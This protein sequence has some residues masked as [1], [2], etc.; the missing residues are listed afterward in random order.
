MR[1][2]SIAVTAV[3]ASALAAVIAPT[4]HAYDADTYSYA[5]GHMIQPSDIPSALQMKSAMGFTA[6]QNTD[7]VWLCSDGDTSIGYPGGTDVFY[8][9]Y[10]GKSADQTTTLAESVMQYDSATD[11]IKAF[12]SLKKQLKK[13]DGKS[14][15]VETYEDGSSETWSRLV[16]SGS[17]PMVSVVGVDSQFLNINY[18]NDSS[19]SNYDSDNYQVFTLLNDVIITTAYYTGVE[20]NISTDKRKQVNQVA[21]NS[22]SRWLD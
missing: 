15:G 14:S 8:A 19:G 10:Y 4:A 21:F 9:N 20:L 1:L 12:N 3:A 17:V 16:T 11:A 5:A 7:K 6:N 18:T 13:C 22:V 2:R